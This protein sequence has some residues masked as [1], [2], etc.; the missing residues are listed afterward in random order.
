[1]YEETQ[2]AVKKAFE[3][4]KIL[5]SM[6]PNRFEQLV[7]VTRKI[8]AP[9]KEELEQLMEEN[10]LSFDE[11]TFVWFER[12]YAGAAEA[13][14]FTKEQGKAMLAYAAMLKELGTY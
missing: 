7:E 8:A 2:R 5:F 14:G 9:K 4:G 12:A 11:A 1:M 10:K 13:A 3:I 6:G